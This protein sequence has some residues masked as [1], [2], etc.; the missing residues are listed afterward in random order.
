MSE[1]EEDARTGLAHSV[2]IEFEAEDVRE[3]KNGFVFREIGLGCR[4]IGLD[5]VDFLICPLARLTKIMI[6]WT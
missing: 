1:L 2:I 4:D 3:V 5:T 6:W